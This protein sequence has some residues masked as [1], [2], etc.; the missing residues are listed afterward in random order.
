MQA[1][2]IHFG[3]SLKNLN[4]VYHGKQSKLNIL[5]NTCPLF[6]SIP[7]LSSIGHYHSWVVNK[8]DLPSELVVTSEAL[9]GEIMSLR[10]Q[11]LPVYGVQFHPES[12]LTQHGLKIMQNWLETV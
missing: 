8:S 6:A 11:W 12:I 4:R 2:A 5:D 9:N 3:G 10:H 1:L 7:E